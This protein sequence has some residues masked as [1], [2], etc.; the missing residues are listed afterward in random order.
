MIKIDSINYLLGKRL[1]SLCFLVVVL[2]FRTFICHGQTDNLAT[3]STDNIVIHFRLD[4]TAI[5]RSYMNNTE[6][7]KRIHQLFTDTLSIADFDLLLV[8][9][10]ASPEGDFNYNMDLSKARLNTIQQ[11]I[12]ETYPTLEQ[13][14]THYKNIGED[15]EEFRRLLAASTVLP[16][17]KQVLQIVDMTYHPDLKEKNLKK[18]ADGKPWRYIQRYIL[19]Q[20]RYGISIIKQ[21]RK[22]QV[23]YIESPKIKMARMSPAQ[24]PLVA[25]NK[26]ETEI[27][28]RKP[29]FAF[30]TNL[31]LDAVSALNI[32]AEVPIGKKWS[33]AGEWVFPWWSNSNANFTMDMLSAHTEV[34]YW[35]GN[36]ERREVLTGW[37]VGLYGGVGK[38]D[39][40]PFSSSGVQ[41]EFFDVGAVAGYAHSIGRNFRMEYSLGVAFV[42]TNYQKYDKVWDTKYGNI[43]VVRY[44]WMSHKA[45]S[46]LPTRAKIS[47]VWLLHYKKTKRIVW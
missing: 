42:Q 28:I 26:R 13:H 10:A 33:V 37:N 47:F 16:H 2:L 25:C 8:V 38:Y 44:P 9:A 35:L 30:K 6:N 19:P 20:I 46:I 31:L 3:N 32:E 34:K 22:I 45:T 40:Q 12:Q 21:E 29:L 17:K 27:T 41:G 24:A 7:L 36:R 1:R 4:D 23:D 5:D 43:K 39:L 11:Y 18:L 15:W 14:I